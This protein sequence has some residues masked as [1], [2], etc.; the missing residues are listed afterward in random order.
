MRKISKSRTDDD[1]VSSTNGSG[2][3][4]NDDQPEADQS[5][6]QNE[7]EASKQ[8]DG[9]NE[10]DSEHNTSRSRSKSR[11]SKGGKGK[12][13]DN[14]EEIETKNNVNSDEDSEVSKETKKRTTKSKAKG[15][16]KKGKT[17]RESKQEDDEEEYEVESI[18][19][20]KRIKGKLH[21]LIRWKGFSADSDSWE[22][23]DTL[24]CP[25]I[26]SKYNEEKENPI[27]KG[28]RKSKKKE[29]KVPAKRTKTSWDSQQAD[30]NA[31]YEVDRILE[32]HRKKNGQREFLIHWKGWSNKFDSWE[33][34]KNLNCPDLIKKF[35]DKVDAAQLIEAPTLRVSR[36]STNRFTL[37]AHSTGRRLSKR[38]GQRQR[39]RYD[40]AE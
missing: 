14:D 33:P 40:D 1:V 32:V 37:Q 36:E 9:I 5:G 26:V 10:G 24:S 38:K 7:S 2:S 19:D 3:L 17:V 6:E 35:M 4:A 31:E 29:S 18:I 23:H 28:K 20:S 27:K 21:Y 34:E 15:K 16:A 8:S 13:D 25:D 12:K 22:P 30:E 11:K 39:V